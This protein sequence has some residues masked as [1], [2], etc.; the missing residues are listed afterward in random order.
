[1]LEFYVLILY[2]YNLIRFLIHSLSLPLFA[3]S[4]VVPRVIL[5]PLTLTRWRVPAGELDGGL[6]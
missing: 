4:A 1:M 5:E 3:S 6:F 2:L